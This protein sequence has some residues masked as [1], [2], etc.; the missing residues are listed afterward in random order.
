MSLSDLPLELFQ[1][2]ISHATCGDED[3]GI[4]YASREVVSIARVHSTY[5]LCCF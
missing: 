1:Q 3:D 5:I 4:R 2:I